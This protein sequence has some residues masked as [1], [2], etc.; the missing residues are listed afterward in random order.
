MFFHVFAV[1]MAGKT[2]APIRLT[3][4]ILF[5]LASI[6][7]RHMQKHNQWKRYIHIRP[8]QYFSMPRTKWQV[9][10]G[11]FRHSSLKINPRLCLTFTLTY[12]SDVRSSVSTL[13][14]E[15]RAKVLTHAYKWVTHVEI[16]LSPLSCESR[17]GYFNEL[18]L[19]TIWISYQQNYTIY[20]ILPKESQ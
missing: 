20:V 15:L 14:G 16:S 7:A 18:H 5:L 6:S 1:R 8:K 19:H 12:L 3:V 2:K 13:S 10:S 4:S 17:F 11:C 9:N